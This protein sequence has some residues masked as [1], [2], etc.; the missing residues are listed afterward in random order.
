MLSFVVL[1]EVG[2]EKLKFGPKIV[3]ILLSINQIK[4][5]RLTEMVLL[6]THNLC[7]SWRLIFNLMTLLFCLFGL[8]LYIQVISYGHVGMVSSQNHTFFLGKLD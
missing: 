4:K 5:N 3:I 7:F 6:C 8:M 1:L 2:S